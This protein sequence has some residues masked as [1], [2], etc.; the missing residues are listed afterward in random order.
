[1]D[2]QGSFFARAT[3]YFGD[4]VDE[5]KKVSCPTRQETT[6]ATIVTSL[7]IV[8]LALL[9]A[10]MDLVFQKIMSVVIG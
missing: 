8:G 4:S 2:N 9:V 1:M 6:Q 7:I 10:L 3:Q 5:L